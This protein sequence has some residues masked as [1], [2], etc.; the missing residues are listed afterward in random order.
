MSDPKKV[1]GLFFRS[2]LDSSA[3]AFLQ[4]ADQNEIFVASALGQSARLRFP[5]D[6][7]RSVFVDRYNLPESRKS[8]TRPTMALTAD[9][10]RLFLTSD[11]K[12]IR[13]IDLP[14]N[15]VAR[16]WSENVI[17]TA[18][19]IAADDETIAVGGLHSIRLY[20]TRTGE[21][22]RELSKNLDL[23]N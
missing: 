23:E 14:S 17:V 15:Y 5:D 16:E 20:D 22:K 9:Q 7:A 21:L 4:S 11:T 6:S 1:S 12:V 19:T 2:R 18:T 3:G 8:G 13:L 10:K